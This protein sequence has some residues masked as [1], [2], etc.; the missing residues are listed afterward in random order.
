MS[1]VLFEHASFECKLETSGRR[2]STSRKFGVLFKD[3]LRLMSAGHPWN[4]I[5]LWSITV[6][7]SNRPVFLHLSNEM[8]VNYRC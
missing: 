2:F 5:P 7:A 1:E 6:A 3:G 8:S 4:V